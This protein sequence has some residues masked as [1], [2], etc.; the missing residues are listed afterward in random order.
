MDSRTKSVLRNGPLPANIHT[1][2]HRE[3]ENT[4]ELLKLSYISTY[5][6]A[7]QS[8]LLLFSN[9]VALPLPLLL[10]LS[11]H[12]TAVFIKIFIFKNDNSAG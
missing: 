4:A 3:T 9:S 8:P 7:L 2:Q 5:L 6:N 1:Q 12:P 10:S 11:L